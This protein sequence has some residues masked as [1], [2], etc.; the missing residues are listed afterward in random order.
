M[1]YL[2]KQLFEYALTVIHKACIQLKKGRK[3]YICVCVCRLFSHVRLSVIPWTVVC[4]APLSMEFS[5]QEYWRG[6]GISFSKRVGISF[7]KEIFPD[8]GIE[9][10]SQALQA[11]SLPSEAPESALTVWEMGTTSILPGQATRVCA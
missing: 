7:S 9:P 2:L 8:P 3:K 1:W 4:Q 6:I 10:W 11:D 5:R